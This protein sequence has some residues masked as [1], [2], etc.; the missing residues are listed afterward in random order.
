MT[1]LRF[2]K[3]LFGSAEV[4][5]DGAAENHPDIATA[6]ELRESSMSATVPGLRRHDNRVSLLGN[7]AIFGVDGPLTGCVVRLSALDLE[8][9]S[10]S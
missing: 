2:P 8:D 6:L 4:R 9:R 3:H 1:T 5:R 7:F 10:V